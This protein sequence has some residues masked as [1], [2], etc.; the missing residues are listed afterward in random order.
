MAADRGADF[1]VLSPVAAT[2]THP[3]A[4]PLGWDGWAAARADHALPVYA[5]GGLG[6]DDLDVAARHNAQGVAAI[7]GFWPATRV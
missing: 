5:L 1:A 2:A 6:S 7:R 3:G 4:V